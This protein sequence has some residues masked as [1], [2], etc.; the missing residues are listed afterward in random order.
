M[1]RTRRKE[2]ETMATAGIDLVGVRF[3][4]MGRSPGQAEAREAERAADLVKGGPMLEPSHA[5]VGLAEGWETR[6][7]THQPRR[8]LHHA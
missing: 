8:K 5:D 2:A 6:Q 4:G 3:D 1:V 7:R